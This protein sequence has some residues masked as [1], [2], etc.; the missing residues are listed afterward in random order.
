MPIATSTSSANGTSW[1]VDVVE[2]TVRA[3]TRKVRTWPK[4]ASDEATRITGQA[5]R[6]SSA[7]AQVGR[8]G[9]HHPRPPSGPVAQQRAATEHDHDQPADDEGG[10]HRHR[11][12]DRRGQGQQ[13]QHGEHDLDQLSGHAVPDDGPRT[14]REVPGLAAMAHGAV[15]VA[16]DSPGR[17]LLRNC[18]R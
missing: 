8:G 1:S 10:H 14:P 11:R 18:E 17:V 3:A 13:H 6:A 7:G 16:E 12:P 5:R 4:T 2:P 15:H 9:A